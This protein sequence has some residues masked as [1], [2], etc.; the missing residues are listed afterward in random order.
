MIGDPKV[1]SVPVF[2]ILNPEVVH[3]LELDMVDGR[4]YAFK[5]ISNAIE[6]KLDMFEKIDLCLVSDIQHKDQ[7]ILVHL[8]YILSEIE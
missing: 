6:D 8:L 4:K 5:E 2:Y 3:A 1:L 7:I